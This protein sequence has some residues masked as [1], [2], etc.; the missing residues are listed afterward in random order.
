MWSPAAVRHDI[1]R[2]ASVLVGI[3]LCCCMSSA[4]KLAAAELVSSLR[5]SLVSAL[6]LAALVR[7]FFLYSALCYSLF[8]RH[9]GL[10]LLSFEH[11]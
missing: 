4:V 10:S 8:R 7:R 2:R 9:A 11:A 3:Q 6:E 1:S 5:A